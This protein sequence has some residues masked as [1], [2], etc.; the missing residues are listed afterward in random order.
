MVYKILNSHGD[1]HHFVALGN[2][3]NDHET[4]IKYYLEKEDVYSGKECIS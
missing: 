2:I 4:V 3:N 1:A